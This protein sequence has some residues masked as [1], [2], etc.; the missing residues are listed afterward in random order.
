MRRPRYSGCLLR[1][2]R[3]F[4]LQYTIGGVRYRE[5]AET[6][7]REVAAKKL[8]AKIAAARTG[9]LPQKPTTCEALATLYMESMRAR[10]KP[11]TYE[12]TEGLW[13]LHL[14]PT[15]SKRNP[16]TILPADLDLHVAAEKKAGVSECFINRQLTILRAMLRFGARN[17]VLRLEDIPEIRK[18]DERPYI[19]MGAV[20]SADFMMLENQIPDEQEWLRLLCLLGYTFGFRK[21]ELLFLRVKNVDLQRHVILLEIGSTKNRMPRRVFINPKGKI[22]KMLAQA[23][24]GKSP[25]AYV[26]SRDEKGSVP[27]RD[28]RTDW[29]RIV[30]AAS[31]RTGSGKENFLTFH[32]LRRTAIRNMAAA[33]IG[34]HEAQSLA[35]HLSVDV[36]RRYRA[37]S[38]SYLR[39]LS[40][41]IDLE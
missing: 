11:H 24:R 3:I 4:H 22:H 39:E 18:F 20:D 15:F 35:G 38:E 31:I 2:G 37:L 13:R 25:E 9:N 6:D 27:V 8:A 21:N 26:I 1:R 5:S 7:N 14:S 28:F 34:E 33:G 23:V 19:R 16:A 36:H 32:D 41:K 30:R 40:A 12:W 10:W 17:K 29:E